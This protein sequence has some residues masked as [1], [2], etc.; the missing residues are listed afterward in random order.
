MLKRKLIDNE[1]LSEE[2]LIKRMRTINNVDN[3][4]LCRLKFFLKNVIN[5]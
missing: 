2:H 5:F 1:G 4:R 3:E